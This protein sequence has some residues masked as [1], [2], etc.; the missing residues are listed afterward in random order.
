MVRKPADL[1]QDELRNSHPVVLIS[2]NGLPIYYRWRLGAAVFGESPTGD[3][4][5]YYESIRYSL[6]ELIPDPGLDSYRVTLEMRQLEVKPMGPGDKETHSYIG[7]YF[8]HIEQLGDNGS[9]IHSVFHV[10]Y[11]DSHANA[12]APQAGLPLP[13]N[14]PVPPRQTNVVRFNA[15]EILLNPNREPTICQRQLGNSKLENHQEIFGL[16]RTF[17]I[18]VTPKDVVVSLKQNNGDFDEIMSANAEK[19]QGALNALQKQV[20]KDNPGT[21]MTV[22]I[23]KPR[24]PMGIWSYR[25]SLALRNV[26][27]APLPAP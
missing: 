9:P 15:S 25:A 27:I 3:K 22:P 12:A 16:W 11:A 7:A 23:W 24:L 21:G 26:S 20:N 18:D 5:C 8:G 14:A 10:P 2:G 17:R 4:T 13:V 19:L 1:I 6:L